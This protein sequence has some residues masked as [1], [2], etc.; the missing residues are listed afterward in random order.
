MNHAIKQGC[1][2]EVDPLAIVLDSWPAVYMCRKCGEGFHKPEDVE[3]FRRQ[4]E[5]EP[6]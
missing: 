3:A 4:I 5:R 1:D 6:K 2:H